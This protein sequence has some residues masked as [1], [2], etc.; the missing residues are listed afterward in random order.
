MLPKHQVSYIIPCKII[1]DFQS[2]GQNPSELA[3]KRI[4]HHPPRAGADFYFFTREQLLTEAQSQWYPYSFG[5]KIAQVHHDLRR[6]AALRMQPCFE[7]NNGDIFTAPGNAD[8]AIMGRRLG[9]LFGALEGAIA[10]H[11][12]PIRTV[13]LQESMREKDRF[14]D[15]P[16]RISRFQPAREIA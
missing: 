9:K 6:C 1:F 11:H 14:L 2:G 4:D 15:S 10:D 12:N 7:P 13:A 16:R 3:R 5:G 8:E